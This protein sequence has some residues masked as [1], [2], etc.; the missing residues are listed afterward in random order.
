LDWTRRQS[1]Q[2]GLGALAAISGSRGAAAQNYPARPM[3]LVVPFARAG[4]SA[5]Q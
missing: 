3:T 1:L 4:I 5:S 2:V